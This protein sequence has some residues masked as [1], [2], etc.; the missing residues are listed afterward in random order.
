M[1]VVAIVPRRVI[2]LVLHHGLQLV[3]E[4]FILQLHRVCCLL[5]SA[6]AF[7]IG[8]VVKGPTQRYQLIVIGIVELRELPHTVTIDVL[9]VWHAIFFVFITLTLVFRHLFVL[10]LVVAPLVQ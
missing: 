7:D 6:T 9:T 3:E 8:V 2:I 1:L 4:L 5:A 10:F